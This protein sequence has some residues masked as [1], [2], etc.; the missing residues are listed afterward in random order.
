CPGLHLLSQEGSRRQRTLLSRGPGRSPQTCAGEPEP[1]GRSGKSRRPLAEAREVHDR[2]GATADR[3]GATAA[4]P[5][6]PRAAGCATPL[7]ATPLLLSPDE[8]PARG[9][10]RPGA[11]VTQ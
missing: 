8:G 3:G 7:D 10:S 5:E 9:G 1:D 4:D 11:G 2:G 6:P